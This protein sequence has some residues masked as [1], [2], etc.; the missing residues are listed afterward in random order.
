MKKTK[1][2]RSLLAACSI[3]ALTA[4]M[5]GCVHDGGSDDEPETEMEPMPEPEPEEEPEE[6]MEPMEPEPVAVNLPTLP[7]GAMYA[8]SAATHEIAAG[9]AATNGGVMFSCAAGGEDCMV[10]VSNRMATSTGGTVTATLT[11]AAQMAYDAQQAAMMAEMNG[12]AAGLYEALTRSEGADDIFGTGVMI[13]PVQ[14][15]EAGW[16]ANTIPDIIITRGLTGDVSVMRDRAHWEGAAMDAASAGAA[17]WA[18]KE[19]T[20]G[21]TQ[22]ITVYSN[23]ENAVRED[24]EADAGSSI[25]RRGQTNAG[26]ILHLPDATTDANGVLTLPIASMVDA[27]QQGLLDLDYF[28]GKKA[29]ASGTVTY[30]YQD[31]PDP[32]P[33]NRGK[34]FT[35]TFHGASGTYTCTVAAGT[36]CTIAVTPANA[37]APTAYVATGEWTFTPDGETNDK[38][39]A[40]LVK[41]DNNWLAFGWWMEEPESTGPGGEYLYNARVF[42]D[43][44]D[45]FDHASLANLGRLDLTYEGPAAGLYARQANETDG[46]TSARGEFSADASLTARFGV[47]Q[48]GNTIADVSGTIDNFANSDGVDMSGWML[49]LQQATAAA[50]AGATGADV[51]AGTATNVTGSWE[52]TL[53]GPHAGGA[54]PTGIAGRFFSSIDGNTAVAGGF[55]AERE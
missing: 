20:N 21:A 39:D 43:G 52:Y 14:I 13:T 5:Y 48:G 42:Y 1:L 8:L 49:N 46:V 4:V 3:V 41:Q 24:F 16:D 28:P 19:L 54:Y 31:N 35:G 23:I 17:G 30:N 25:Y 6:P 45:E 10:T 9:R 55:G 15:P 27:A 22:S 18:G 34:T 11:A 51:T 26:D 33:R 44:A 29:P 50:N 37:T 2:T 7:M 32:G 12:R 38:N 40:Q 47:V 36:P 53:Y